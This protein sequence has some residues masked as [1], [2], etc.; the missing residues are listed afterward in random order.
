[1][2]SLI[3]NLSTPKDRVRSE[4]QS[5]RSEYELAR[6]NYR[7]ALGRAKDLGLA[8]TV[9]ARAVGTTEAAVRMYFKRRSNG[10]DPGHRLP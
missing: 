1:M 7:E 2:Q 9:I 5:R 10:A 6:E 4:L 3:P 8:N